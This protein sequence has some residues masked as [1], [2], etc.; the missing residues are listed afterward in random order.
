VINGLSIPVLIVTSFE[1]GLLQAPTRQMAV[2]EVVET[3]LSVI[4][5]PILPLDQTVI[6]TQPVELNVTLSPPQTWILLVEITGAVGLVTVIFTAFEA[7]LTQALDC[8]QVAVMV[9]SVVGR[10]V[11]VF[12]F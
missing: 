2:N 12:P 6:P 10:M 8:T 11:M 4:L 3:S 1:R 5:L 9:T 7:S